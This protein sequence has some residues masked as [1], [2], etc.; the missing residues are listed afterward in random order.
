MKVESCL[1]QGHLIAAEVGGNSGLWSLCSLWRMLCLSDCVQCGGAETEKG[2]KDTASIQRLYTALLQMRSSSKSHPHS[3]K[4][5]VSLTSF[6]STCKHPVPPLC[7]A[8]CWVL[9]QGRE[10]FQVL[11]LEELNL[12]Q[13][14]ETEHKQ[15]AVKVWGV[16]PVPEGVINLASGYQGRPSGRQ[17]GGVGPK[18]QMRCEFQAAGATSSGSRARVGQLFLEG[19]C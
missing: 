13:Q 4:S 16:L 2:R 6:L 17:P 1:S 11:A 19:A 7:L 10:S 9:G 5:Q 3:G 18:Q 14:L 15:T 8:L 12:V